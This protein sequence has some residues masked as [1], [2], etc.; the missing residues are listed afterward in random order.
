MRDYYQI[1]GLPPGATPEELKSAYR[2]LALKHHPDRNPGDRVA[3]E[4]FKQISEAYQV[5]SDPEK[6]HLYDLYG[7][8]GL[9]GMDLGGF[10]GFDDVFGSFGEIF[11]DFFGFGRTRTRKNRPQPGADL[12]HQVDITLDDV[13]KG[14]EADL[15]IPRRAVCPA[16]QGNGMAPGAKRRTCSRCGGRGQVAQSRGLL[17]VYATC[18]GCRGE[19]SFIASPCETCQ[20]TGTVMERRRMQVR[21]PP[22]VDHGTRLRLRG[23]GERGRFGGPPGDLY[24]EVSL[25]PHPLF[26]RKGKDLHYR[27]HLS[28]VA[29]ALGQEI[30]VPTLNGQAPLT[31]PPGTQSGEVFRLPGEGVPDLRSRKPG[32]LVVEIQLKTPSILNEQQEELLREFLRLEGEAALPE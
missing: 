30:T 11:E 19:G 4:E 6:R 10:G 7:H 5:L 15:E 2:R 29:A 13:V 21:I 17:R 20:G 12:R 9:N 8:A 18:P 1:L 25:A 24:L 28:F 27:I 26:T 22:G 32:D 31:I 16:C 23:E 14:M 3:E